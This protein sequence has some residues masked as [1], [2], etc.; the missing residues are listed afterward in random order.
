MS[1][2]HFEIK[3]QQVI[4]TVFTGKNVIATALLTVSLRILMLLTD[5][6]EQKTGA[7]KGQALKRSR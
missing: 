7:L 4:L 6:S 5:R 3:N 1:L 2:A